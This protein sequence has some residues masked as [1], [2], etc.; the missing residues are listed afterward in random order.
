MGAQTNPM[1][2]MQ[3][4]LLKLYATGITEQQLLD[5]RRI[6]AAYFGNLIDREMIALWEEKNMDDTVIETWK[7]ERL[8]TPY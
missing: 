1:S 4:E 8:R 3:L 7:Q 5:I 2:N 6:L